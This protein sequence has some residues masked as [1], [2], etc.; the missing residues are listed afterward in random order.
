[1]ETN[2][3]SLLRCTIK[4]SADVMKKLAKYAAYILGTLIAGTLAIFGALGVWAIS[5]DPV[6]KIV[7]SIV[8][9]LFSIPWYYYAAVASI[10][11]PIAGIVAYAF[12]WCVTREL[13]EEDWESNEAEDTAL[14]TLTFAFAIVIAFAFAFA[15]TFA[16]LS[17]IAFAFAFA[18]TFAAIVAA[19]ALAFIDSKAFLFI[20]AYL[21]YRK[22]VKAE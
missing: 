16:A 3:K 19:I 15:I 9:F 1:M 8:S 22:R 13:T 12:L 6:Y 21:H 20:G 11:V 2:D 7:D 10:V 18:T 5:A 4:K 17:A 14:F